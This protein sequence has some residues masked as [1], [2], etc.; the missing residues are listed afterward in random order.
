[1]SY[2]NIQAVID[3]ARASTVPHQVEVGQVYLLAN[4]HGGVDRVDLTGDEYRAAPRFKIG[5]V[6]VRDAASFIAYWEKHSDDGSEIYADRKAGTVTAVL[7]AHADDAPRF[8][9]HRLALELRHTD[10][11]LAW[12]QRSGKLQ[13]QVAFAEFIEDHRADI[14]SPPAA[15]LLELAQTF[16]ATTKVTFRSGTALKSGQRQLTYVEEQNATAGSKGQITIPDEFQLALPIYEGA[17]VA[18]AVTARL[19]YRIDGDGKLGLM[20]I[21][22]QLTEVVNAA[23]EGVV[24]LLDDQVSVPILRGVPA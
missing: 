1:M 16:Q 10:A 6:I 12:Q 24:A 4:G 5:K 19:R 11:F 9:R 3:T 23:F 2:D 17:E 7:D 18:D 20:F 21:L 13:P 8:G 15:D 22:D 14:A